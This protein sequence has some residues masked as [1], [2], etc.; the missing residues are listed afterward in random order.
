[1]QRDT[2]PLL[3]VED[4]WTVNSVTFQTVLRLVS[5]YRPGTSLPTRKSLL[6]YD[7]VTTN[8][9]VQLKFVKTV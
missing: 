1:M 5:T 7:L 6:V 3:M 8:D 2:Y 9:Q 4:D